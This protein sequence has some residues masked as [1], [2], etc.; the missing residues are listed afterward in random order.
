[1]IMKKVASIDDVEISYETLGE[2]DYPLVLISGWG[3]PT[4]RDAWRHQLSLASQFKLVLLDL[5]GHGLSDKN[6]EVYTMQLFAQDVRAVVEKLDLQNAILIGHSMGGPV[7]MET[8]RLISHRIKGMIALDS[9]F[10]KPSS[11]YVKRDEGIIAE[12]E[13]QMLDDFSGFILGLLRSWINDK[14]DPVDVEDIEQLPM[15]LDQRS[16]ISAFNE[17]QR[18]NMFDIL[19]EIETPMKCIVAG[20]SCPKEDRPEYDRLFDA[21]YLE[22]LS[23]LLLFEDPVTFNEVLI[24]QI[25][26][27]SK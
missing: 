3:T 11:I 10:P 25:N 23:H 12:I 1:M 27:L 2:G 17:I 6:R 5:A 4:A 22:D 18:W 24:E 7:I 16:M 13:T 15:T 21:V 20:N 26:E 14:F 9:L 8:E 19:S